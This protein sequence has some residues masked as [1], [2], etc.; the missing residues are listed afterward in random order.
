MNAQYMH[1]YTYT[2]DVGQMAHF[3]FWRGKVWRMDRLSQ[4][5]IMIA[6]HA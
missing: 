3:K 6:R 1:V 2:A 4:K 5:L